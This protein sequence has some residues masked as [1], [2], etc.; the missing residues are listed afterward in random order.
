MYV[1]FV[2]LH[3]CLC[4]ATME[5]VK[6]VMDLLLIA[7]LHI[8]FH[9]VSMWRRVVCTEIQKFEHSNVK[10]KHLNAIIGSHS[11]YNQMYL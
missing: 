6:L 3:R 4:G 2:H 9:L 10:S 8:R 1:H 5:T 7:V 11:V